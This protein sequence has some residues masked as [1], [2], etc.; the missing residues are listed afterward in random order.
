MKV[1]LSSIAKI[2]TGV[3]AKT[4]P[5]GKAIY[6][7][8]KNFDESGMILE[9]IFQNLEIN[10]NTEKH[11]LKTGDIIFCA[12]GIK[13]FAYSFKEKKTL[14]VASTTFFVIQLKSNEFL[15]EFLTWFLNFPSNLGFLKKNSIGSS[16][17]SIPKSVLENLEIPILSIEKQKQIL[18]I[19]ELEQ[20]EKQIKEKLS[21]LRE[22]F[23]EQ[24]LLK[25]IKQL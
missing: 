6:L 16:I 10:K 3:F 22:K 13:N 7:Q 18:K 15:P 11:I 2:K 5:K 14:A 4:L 25:T 17:P 9:P 24:K 1:K 8:A 19:S 21:K 12:K 23:I 20:K